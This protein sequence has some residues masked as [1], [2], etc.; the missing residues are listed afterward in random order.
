MNTGRT[1]IIIPAYNEGAAIVQLLE[2]INS[3]A[4]NLSEQLTVL[5]VD[6]G[7]DDDTVSRI[8]NVSLTSVNIR[9]ISLLYNQGHQTAIAQ[10]LLFAHSEKASGAIIMDGDGED[11]PAAI[12]ELLKL[13]DYDIVNVTRGRRSESLAFRISYSIYRFFFYLITNKKMNFGNYCMISERVIEIFSR[14]TFIHFAAFLSKLRFKT[15]TIRS[16][17]RQRLGGKTKMNASNLIHHAFRSFAE[18][19]ESLLMIFLRLFIILFVLFILLIGY[20]IYLKI[21]TE[22][23]ILGWTSTFGIG[24]LTSALICVGF[25]V[26]GV[27]LLNI[28]QRNILPPTVNYKVVR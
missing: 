25:F 17:R 7:S 2:E 24:L 28:T 12:Q 26:L 20:I 11:D 5:V 16:D 13:K 3:V 10:G 15:A 4:S 9:I 14:R 23:P 8:A 1:F 27:L 21:F 22:Y 18:Y 19:G 6:D